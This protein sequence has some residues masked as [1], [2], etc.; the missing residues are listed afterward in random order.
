MSSSLD[1]SEKWFYVMGNGLHNGPVRASF[2]TIYIKSGSIT[3]DTLVW[4]EGQGDW[5]PLKETELHILFD[6][7]VLPPPLPLRHPQQ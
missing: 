6:N 3:P 5:L 1:D 4:T 2:I 7:V